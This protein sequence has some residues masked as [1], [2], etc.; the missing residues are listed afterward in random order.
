MTG[1]V[2]PSGSEV[3][4]A[5]LA[6]FARGHHQA[7]PRQRPTGSRYATWSL[8]Q[9]WTF[10]G[11]CTAHQTRLP[12]APSRV[13]RGTSS[14]VT[15]ESAPI[16]DGRSA[17]FVASAGI[18]VAARTNWREHSPRHS[19][20]PLGLGPGGFRLT[21]C[22]RCVSGPPVLEYLFARQRH[23]QQPPPEPGAQ[24]RILPRALVRGINSNTLTILTRR[25]RESVTCGFA[26]PHRARPCSAISPPA[27]SSWRC[28]RFTRHAKRPGQASR[29]ARRCRTELRAWPGLPLAT[30]A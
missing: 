19:P 22:V 7:G 28:G 29:R 6:S 18:L 4:G 25:S 10:G 20:A 2:G 23:A 24:V 16:C 21:S 11:W 13:R 14:A 8:S 3:T 15:W 26:T 5:G 1:W 30:S 9:N 12:C 17:S 27:V